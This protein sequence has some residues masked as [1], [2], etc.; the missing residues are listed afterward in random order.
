MQMTRCLA[1]DLGPEN[2]RVNA[3]CPGTIDTPAT[4]THATKLGLTKAE[5]VEKTIG[6]HFIKRLG[7]TLDCAY[8]SLF[9]ASDES[10]F[11]TGTHI[12]L[13]GGYTVH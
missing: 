9:L 8:A 3:V 6:D 1:M 5:L 2:I 13:D 11:I 4:T 7:S 10:S 12:M